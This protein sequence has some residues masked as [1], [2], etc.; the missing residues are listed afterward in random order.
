[1][2]KQMIKK[3]G[4]VACAALLAACIQV[5]ADM[6][7]ASGMLAEI[8]AAA[9]QANAAWAAAAN[10]GDTDALEAAQAVVGA[11]QAA[12]E[13]AL[14]AYAALEASGGSNDAAMEAIEDALS[15]A[16]GALGEEK[17][18]DAGEA[19]P[20]GEGDDEDKLPNPYDVPWQSDGLRELYEELFNIVQSASA[21]GG[22][23][24]PD[25]DATNI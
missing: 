5:R 19:D 16:K 8:A 22:A 3:M 13:E 9:T 6:A 25:R 18:G 17:Q 7:A 15:S 21:Q 10:S 14:K 1:M 11:V 23:E 2:Q 20:A 4:W 24:F 12:S